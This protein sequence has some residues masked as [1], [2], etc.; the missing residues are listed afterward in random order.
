M[1]LSISNVVG[2]HLFDKQLCGIVPWQH[3]D[4][5]PRKII[6][7]DCSCPA[8]IGLCKHLFLVSIVA[9]VPYSL[10]HT[11]ATR[12]PT[13]TT[14]TTNRPVSN[15]VNSS[16][17]EEFKASLLLDNKEQMHVLGARLNKEMALA[18]ERLTTNSDYEYVLNGM[19]LLLQRFEK[20]NHPNAGPA[21]GPAKVKSCQY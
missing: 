21:A 19:K 14:T 15:N 4:S 17:T 2:C 8:A 6:V 20:V 3:E 12:P 16:V 13:T 10:R 1:T 5:L 9:L 7:S 18:E 11:P